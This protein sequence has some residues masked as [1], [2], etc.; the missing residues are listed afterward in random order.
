M[1]TICAV[2][3]SHLSFY[4]LLIIV[5][6]YLLTYL[7]TYTSDADLTPSFQQEIANHVRGTVDH[8]LDAPPEFMDEWLDR[9]F[10]PAVVLLHL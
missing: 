1:C 7:L 5:L 10:V 8:D 2:C 6:T 4:S 9:A 3:A